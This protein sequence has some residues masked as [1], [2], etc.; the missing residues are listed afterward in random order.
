MGCIRWL[1]QFVKQCKGSSD[2]LRHV[3]LK[4]PDF[5]NTGVELD[6]VVFRWPSPLG[7]TPVWEPPGNG[8]IEHYVSR[9]VTCAVFSC[10]STRNFLTSWPLVTAGGQA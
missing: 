1:R 6:A 3:C 4:D 10:K 9:T 2:N 8:H 7:A 5:G